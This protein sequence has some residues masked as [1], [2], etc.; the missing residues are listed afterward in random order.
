LGTP[1]ILILEN[2]FSKNLGKI[3]LVQVWVFRFEFWKDKDGG[4]GVSREVLRK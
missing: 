1:K 2:V 4:H 3:S